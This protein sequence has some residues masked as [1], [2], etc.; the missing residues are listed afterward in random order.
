VTAPEIVLINGTAGSGISPLDRGLQFGDGLFETIACRHGRARLLAWHLERLELGCARL[1]IQ[2]REAEQVRAEVHA[3]A[4]E[5][6]RSII[7]VIVTRGDAQAR[8]YAPTGNEKA[9]RI[10]VR[11]PWPHETAATSQDGVKVCTL[12]MR[13][14]ENPALAGIKHTNRLEQILARAEWSSA[15]VAEGILFSSSGNLVSG[16]MTN[17]FIVRGSQVQTPVIDRCGVA[18]VMRRLVLREAMRAHISVQECV[19][20]ADDLERAEE[21]FLTNA[22]IGIWPVRELDGRVFVPGPV[23]RRLQ[24]LIAP[25]LEE[26]ADE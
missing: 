1:G 2:L 5:A 24:Q 7:K 6:D 22:R 21:L 17:A 12:A 9:T 15:D 14:G 25:P 16:T 23:T 3:L 4:R 26:P 18:G 13:L 20:R 19:L 10:T 8:G 11:Y